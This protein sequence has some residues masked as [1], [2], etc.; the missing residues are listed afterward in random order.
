MNISRQFRIGKYYSITCGQSFEYLLQQ[1]LVS[2]FIFEIIAMWSAI[3]TLQLW[4]QARVK[5][6]VHVHVYYSLWR[7]KVFVSSISEGGMQ[8]N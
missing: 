3:L 1:C 4:S 5:I 8:V 7:R 6:H 2:A